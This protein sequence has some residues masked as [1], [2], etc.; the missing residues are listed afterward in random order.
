MKLQTYSQQMSVWLQQTCNRNA[1]DLG[2][3]LLV[4]RG[5]RGDLISHCNIAALNYN[6]DE[7]G[8]LGKIFLM[9]EQL[10][11]TKNLLGTD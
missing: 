11:I 1:T 10:H 7:V 5:V 3:V 8:N 2:I 9:G 6:Y 4:W